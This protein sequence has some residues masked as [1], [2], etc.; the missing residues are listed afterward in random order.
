MRRQFGRLRAVTWTV[1]CIVVA[2]AGPD[3]RTVQAGETGVAMKLPDIGACQVRSGV[4]NLVGEKVMTRTA[5]T[6]ETIAAYAPS[7]TLGDGDRLGKVIA[8]W[9][10]APSAEPRFELRFLLRLTCADGTTHVIAGSRTQPNGTVFLSV[11]GVPG[12]TQSPIRQD[13]EGLAGGAH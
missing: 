5:I 12:T 11:D 13:L 9:T 7:V 2:A 3:F 4:L 8:G 10:I 1:A 6:P